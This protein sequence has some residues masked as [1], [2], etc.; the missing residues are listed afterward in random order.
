MKFND[1]RPDDHVGWQQMER[2][3]RHALQQVRKGHARSWMVTPLPDR[4]TASHV[5]FST[6]VRAAVQSW[7]DH[8]HELSGPFDFGPPAWSLSHSGAWGAFGAARNAIGID[9]EVDRDL[10]NPRRLWDR[11]A[12]YSEQ[13]QATRHFETNP[14]QGLWTAKEAVS[15]AMGLGITMD[16][17]DM[18]WEPNGRGAVVVVEQA[19]A[20]PR[21]WDVEQ[22]RGSGYWLAIATEVDTPSQI[23]RFLQDFE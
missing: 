10:Q 22:V 11:I 3:V 15:K 18:R 23:G 6:T 1:L 19:G 2:E 16:F 8:L 14:L 7:M 21:C 12:H 20:P 5:Q 9:L 4:T 13:E 17:R